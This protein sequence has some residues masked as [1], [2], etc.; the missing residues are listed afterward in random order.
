M[1][2]D[3]SAFVALGANLPHE[4]VAGPALLA[5]AI[6]AMRG[7][8]FSLR[9]VSGVWQTEAWPKASGQ[10]DYYNAVVELDAEGFQPQALYQRLTA[11]ERAF[12]RERRVRWAPRTLELDI[13]AIDGFVGTFGPITVP[14]PRM[15]CRAFV[16]AP[17]AE[18]AP[19]WRHPELQRTAGDLLAELAGEY[20][21]HRVGE[22]A[23]A[24]PR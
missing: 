8:G 11:I 9:A 18:I 12:G 20:R 13:V 3:A 15:H 16:L 10:P 21:Y 22:L 24:G 2:A 1:N 14:H 17:L 6:E 5:R 4:G 19:T 7:A 23:L